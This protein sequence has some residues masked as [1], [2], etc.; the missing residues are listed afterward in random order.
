MLY[1]QTSDLFKQLKAHYAT[2]LKEVPWDE[3]LAQVG[4]MYFGI[5]I[6]SQSNPMFDMMSN[7]LMGGSNPFAPKKRE[8]AKVGQAAGADKPGTPQPPA[9]GVD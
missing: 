2:H 3:P 8:P 7:M 6:P 5:K 1:R 4:E 9:P